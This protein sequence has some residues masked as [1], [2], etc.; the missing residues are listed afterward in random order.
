M[1]TEWNVDDQLRRF[2]AELD[3]TEW[4]ASLTRSWRESVCLRSER[5]APTPRSLPQVME[6]CRGSVVAAAKSARK[7]IVTNP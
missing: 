6:F 3:G 1:D 7:Y 5:P 4:R 2:A